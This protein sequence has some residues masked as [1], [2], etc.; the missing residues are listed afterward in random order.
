MV[1]K[2]KTLILISLLFITALICT[3]IIYKRRGTSPVLLMD[4][5][6]GDSEKSYIEDLAYEDNQ[7][8]TV[9]GY[10]ITLKEVIMESS[11]F[12]FF[13][14]YEKNMGGSKFKF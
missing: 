11:R 13:L 5:Y 6:F 4:Y 12:R 1:K 3:A 7:E 2:K 10:V 8:V 9:D 14:D